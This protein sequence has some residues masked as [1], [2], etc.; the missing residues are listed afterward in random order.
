MADTIHFEIVTPLG[1]AFATESTS[2]VLP[3]QQ[4]E[5]E[6]LPG[7]RAL[8]A[9]IDH[10]TVVVAGLD[11]TKHYFVVEPGYVEISD[12][13]VTLLV[14]DCTAASAV[15]LQAARVDLDE[16][17]RAIATAADGL[18]EHL[19]GERERIARARAR[20]EMVERATGRVH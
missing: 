10:G 17:S 8:L 6:I 19:K 1:A 3:S 7:H 4:G 20:I 5:L 16:A 15:D 13:N 11:N 2:V 18:A 14:S 12:G 9:L